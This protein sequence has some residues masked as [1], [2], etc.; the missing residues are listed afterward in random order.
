ML[1]QVLNDFYRCVPVQVGKANRFQQVF[2]K[3]ICNKPGCLKIKFY[4]EW[5]GCRGGET[6]EINIDGSGSDKVS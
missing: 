3:I 6:Q 5:E 1:Q 2:D 4:R